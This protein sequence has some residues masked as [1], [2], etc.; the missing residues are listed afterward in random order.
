MSLSTPC[1]DSS[2]P[3]FPAQRSDS[4]VCGQGLVNELTAELVLARAS[5]R[6]REQIRHYGATT[7]GKQNSA[8]EL[9]QLRVLGLGLLQDGDVGVGVFP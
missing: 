7:I 9:P 5:Y 3:D 4:N 6:F 8:K 1:K 2:Q